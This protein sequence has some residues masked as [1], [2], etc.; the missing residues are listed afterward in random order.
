[1]ANT[2]RGQRALKRWRS[3]FRL[4]RRAVMV[5][6]AV[7]SVG[8]IADLDEDIANPGDLPCRYADRSNSTTHGRRQ[9]DHGLI[10]LNFQQ[11]FKLLNRLAFLHK[12]ADH[13]S[14]MNAFTD[15]WQSK[16]R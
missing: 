5:R 4:R 15:I 9:L 14:F 8:F 6:N 16:G 3:F 12:P 1:M 7:R 13:L 10:R 2:W 11:W